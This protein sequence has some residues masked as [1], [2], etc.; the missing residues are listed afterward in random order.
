MLGL[1]LIVLE[2]KNPEEAAKCVL[3]CYERDYFKKMVGDFSYSPESMMT[4]EISE[5]D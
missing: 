3:R 2:I 1:S 4:S 5:R